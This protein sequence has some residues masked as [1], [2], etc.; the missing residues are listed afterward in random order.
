[1]KLNLVYE[2]NKSGQRLLEAIKSRYQEASW[3]EFLL[4]GAFGNR[5]YY[6]I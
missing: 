1:M 4:E 6:C 5:P 2:N 3:N